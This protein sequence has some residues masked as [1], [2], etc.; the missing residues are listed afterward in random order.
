[1]LGAPGEGRASL[2]VAATP[3]AVERGVKAGAVVKV[4]A[5]AVGGGGGGR[6]NM[7]QAGGK[8]PDKLPDALAAARAEI[9][10]ALASR[11]A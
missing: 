1:M 9:E 4:A 5:A 7:A 10:R 3:G 6:D 11:S 8:D 2:L